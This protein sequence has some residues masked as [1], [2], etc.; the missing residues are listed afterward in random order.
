[1]PN[2][3]SRNRTIGWLSDLKWRHTRQRHP[4]P[5]R[6]WREVVDQLP[7]AHGLDETQRALLGKRAWRLLHEL[8]LTLPV[9]GTDWP[10]AERLRLSA[11][12]ALLA[13]GWE[14]GE[15]AFANVHEVVVVPDAFTREVVEVDEYGVTHEYVDER[16]GETSYQGPVVVSLADVE[17][18]G[19]W[20]GFNVIIHEFCHKLDMG[21]SEDVD[22]LPPLPPGLSAKTWHQVFSVV[23][24]DL[25]D[26]LAHDE[27]TPIDDY[28]ASHPGECFAVCS[29]YFF[30][31]PDILA[32]AYPDLYTLLSRYYGQDPL[33]RLRAFE[34]LSAPEQ[35]DRAVR[36]PHFESP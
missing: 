7:I 3:V 20:S 34:S 29:E 13:L 2:C 26:R 31:A 9:D 10:L 35:G 8:R 12:I 15:S 5:E 33:P 27:P 18:S 23:W 6:L 19:E 11:Q 25:N 28:A 4:L 1:M 21:N 16:V 14:D 24:Q 30:T 32:E 17:H 36:P 22:G